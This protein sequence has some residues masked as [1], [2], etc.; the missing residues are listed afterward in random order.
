MTDNN[1]LRK[2]DLLLVLR[3]ATADIGNE[4]KRQ[5]FICIDLLS[6]RDRTRVAEI[7][8]A[9]PLPL[10][11]LDVGKYMKIRVW[12]MHVNRISRK[13]MRL[14]EKHRIGIIGGRIGKKTGV[15]IQVVVFCPFFGI[16]FYLDFVLGLI[17]W[18]EPITWN[19]TRSDKN[20][21]GRVRIMSIIRTEHDFL[22][23]GFSIRK[24]TYLISSV[25]ES[26]TIRNQESSLKIDII[27]IIS[28]ELLC[29]FRDACL[30]YWDATLKR[31]A[32]FKYVWSPKNKTWIVSITWLVAAL[33]IMING[34]ILLEFSSSEVDSIIYTS[35]VTVHGFVCCIHIRHHCL[36]HKFTP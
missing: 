22:Y 17:K 28:Y 21:M 5:E 35:F 9:T 25:I 33:V 24:S 2:D 16:C 7:T 29:K 12:L 27:Q 6:Q 4:R 31:V 13:K 30:I 8:A 32:T 26:T 36:W 11:Q 10:D 3:T 15:T 18:T 1:N 23:G 14:K 34:Y 19:R 20:G